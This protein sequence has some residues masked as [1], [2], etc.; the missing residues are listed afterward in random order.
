MVT[1]SGR[2]WCATTCKHTHSNTHSAV[3]WPK[4]LLIEENKSKKQ[5]QTV[6]EHCIRVCLTFTSSVCEWLMVWNEA[7]V[8][9]FTVFTVPSLRTSREICQSFFLFVIFLR[10]SQSYYTFDWLTGRVLMWWRFDH[11][12][13]LV[14]WRDAKDTLVKPFNH[15]NSSSMY[16]FI[17]HQL[18]HSFLSISDWKVNWKHLNKMLTNAAFLP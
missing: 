8:P 15:L 13:T 14:A 5:I 2:K 6:D 17:Y 11:E 16:S 10:A 18:F 12:E 9:V 4:Y 7:H 1:K 3:K